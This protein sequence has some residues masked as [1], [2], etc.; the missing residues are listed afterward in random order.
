MRWGRFTSILLGATAASNQQSS[1]MTPEKAS[2]WALGAA[3]AIPWRFILVCCSVCF[4]RLSSLIRRTSNCLPVGCLSSLWWSL[5]FEVL[6]LE[7]I[8][9]FAVTIKLAIIVGVLAALAAYDIQLQSAWFQHEAI[10]ALSHFELL[11][12]S[13]GCSW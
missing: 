6:G 5:G 8:E 7:T 2:Q 9:L 12:C 3:Y 1:I 13:Q 10:Q 4:D 11:A